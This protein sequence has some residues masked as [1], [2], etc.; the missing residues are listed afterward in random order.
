M[1]NDFDPTDELAGLVARLNAGRPADTVER[2]LPPPPP[3]MYILNVDVP[4]ER[5]IVLVVGQSADGEWMAT[6]A[7]LRWHELEEGWD[8]PHDMP[9]A[10]RLANGYAAAFGYHAIAINIK[11]SQLWQ[12]DWGELTKLHGL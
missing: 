8:G 2:E 12:A 5:S 11:S 3:P 1:D 9:T 10:I 7:L 6:I 4:D